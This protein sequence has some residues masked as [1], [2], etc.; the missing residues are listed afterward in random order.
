MCAVDERIVVFWL[1][2]VCVNCYQHMFKHAVTLV[3][4][5]HVL[6]SALVVCGSSKDI[7]GV[8]LESGKLKFPMTGLTLSLSAL[9]GVRGQLVPSPCRNTGTW[10]GTRL[11]GVHV[12][13]KGSLRAR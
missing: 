13:S 8:N 7:S 11:S 6:Y 3:A 4:T 5:K 2:G 10:K 1:P 9:Q 12:N